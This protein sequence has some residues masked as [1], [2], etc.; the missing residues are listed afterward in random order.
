MTLRLVIKVCE[1]CTKTLF[2]TA[3]EK[4]E[5]IEDASTY[6]PDYIQKA[7]YWWLDLDCPVRIE[8]ATDETD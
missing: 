1:G 2:C 6:W 4:L 5:H 8:E 3:K 7:V